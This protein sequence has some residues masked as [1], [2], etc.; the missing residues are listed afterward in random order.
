MGKKEAIYV[1]S[2]KITYKFSQKDSAM[3]LFNYLL[4]V[5]SILGNSN[6]LKEEE[7]NYRLL[8]DLYAL[9]SLLLE[10][11]NLDFISTNEYLNS[12]IRYNYL[13]MIK[14][15][16]AKLLKDRDF[17][18]IKLKK[19]IDA[20]KSTLK[21]VIKKVETS[22]CNPENEKEENFEKK[23]IN[24]NKEEELDS[25][26]FQNL[27]ICSILNNIYPME[28]II[29]YQEFSKFNLNYSKDF[30][31][32]IFDP[33]EFENYYEEKIKNNYSIFEYLYSSYI[34]DV[35][36][37]HQNQIKFNA[38]ANQ[39]NENFLINQ[40]FSTDKIFSQICEFYQKEKFGLKISDLYEMENNFFL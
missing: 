16:Y 37:F 39:T 8:F 34:L 2:E 13:V 27:E 12:S 33:F 11:I 20:C 31:L 14:E 9:Q 3:L 23:D 19:L 21:D 15:Q 38:Y 35:N 28:T 29:C 30:S 36:I 18:Q 17:I 5:L 1:W 10:N 6:L 24:V 7:N 22:N 25:K 32:E 26:D 40:H 4:N